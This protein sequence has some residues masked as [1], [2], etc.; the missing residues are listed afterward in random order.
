MR[1]LASPSCDLSPPLHA[2]SRLPFM[3]PLAS[4]SCALSPPLHAPS[5]LPFMRPLASPSCALSPPLHAP[6][7]LPVPASLLQAAEDKWRQQQEAVRVA[8]ANLGRAEREV[9]LLG[10]EVDAL[11]DLVEEAAV[12]LAH[13]APMLRGLP[14]MLELVEAMR[15]A[16]LRRA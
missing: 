3:R 2:P 16:A 7:R 14:G 9:Q 6:S 8:V 10:D 15:A 11:S 1:P 5:R 12:R 4:P 13:H